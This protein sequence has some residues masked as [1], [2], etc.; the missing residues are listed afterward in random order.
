ML[1]FLSLKVYFYISQPYR[2][3]GLQVESSLLQPQS[4]DI[5]QML[6]LDEMQNRPYFFFG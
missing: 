4:S 2:Q 5:S 3:E 6:S 1:V